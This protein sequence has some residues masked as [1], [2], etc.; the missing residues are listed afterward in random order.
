MMRCQHDYVVKSDVYFQQTQ[1]IPGTEE[2][3]EIVMN[4]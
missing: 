1:V 2:Y 3:E 4:H